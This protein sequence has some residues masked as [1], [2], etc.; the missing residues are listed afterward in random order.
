MDRA[1]ELGRRFF[2][3]ELGTIRGAPVESK[4]IFLRLQESIIFL[5]GTPSTYNKDLQEDKEAMFDAADTINDVIQVCAINFF[6]LRSQT[7]KG[8]CV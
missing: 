7:L 3:R 2:P 4:N 5:E 6:F 8:L 1:L